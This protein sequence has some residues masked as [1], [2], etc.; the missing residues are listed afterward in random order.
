MSAPGRAPT[1]PATECARPTGRPRPAG[2]GSSTGTATNPP[3]NTVSSACP[4]SSRAAAPHLGGAAAWARPAEQ[5]VQRRP[6]GA[7]P[8]RSRASAADAGLGGQSGASPAVAGRSHARSRRDARRVRPRLR[9][10]E[11]RACAP[12]RPR[13]QLAGV[14][15]GGRRRPSSTG[16]RR[17]RR[18]RA[19]ARRRAAARSMP[20][21]SQPERQR[22]QVRRRGRARRLRNRA[23]SVLV[24]T[25]VAVGVV[26]DVERTQP[27]VGQPRAPVTNAIATRGVAE[28]PLRPGLEARLGDGTRRR[29]SSRRPSR[30]GS[31][32]MIARRCCIGMPVRGMRTT[33]G[34]GGTASPAA[35]HV[36]RRRGP[37]RVPGHEL[38]HGL[39]E[40]QIGDRVVRAPQ[41]GDRRQHGLRLAG[42]AD[43][44]T[45][46]PGCSACP[47]GPA[48][49]LRRDGRVGH[50]EQPQPVDD[51]GGGDALLRRLV[52]VR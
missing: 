36:Q 52:R 13:E 43:P 34:S 10:S 1:P 35:Q 28:R 29:R 26:E 32:T 18:R 15:R 21:S 16:R 25:P 17:R 42:A 7:G 38:V 49:E 33:S 23:A 37:R 47:S 50:L 27:G 12:A 30:G 8:R 51:V 46:R 2:A 6:P 22:R 20:S 39:G 11:P 31:G 4:A 14:G 45:C 5:H 44:A 24:A 9:R 3:P 41:L 40:Q 48:G 19:G